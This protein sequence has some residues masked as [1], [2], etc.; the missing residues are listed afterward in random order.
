MIV[1]SFRLMVGTTGR[2]SH[3]AASRQHQLS[4]DGHSRCRRLLYSEV[5]VFTPTGHIETS[6]LDEATKFVRV[7]PAQRQRSH[8]VCTSDL[9]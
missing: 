9:L 7:W 6:P 1:V 5:I 2:A 4:R 3:A 8:N